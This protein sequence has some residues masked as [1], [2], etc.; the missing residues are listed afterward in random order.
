MKPIT[1]VFLIIGV[2]LLCFLVWT[3][4]FDNGGVLALAWN[5]IATEV[6]DMYA[7]INSLTHMK[8]N[9]SVTIELQNA[10]DRTVFDFV[11]QFDSIDKLYFMYYAKTGENT[12]N[13]PN[14]INSYIVNPN[15]VSDLFYPTGWSETIVD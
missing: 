14:L 11:Y 12:I 2:L 10:K 15:N 1:K 8:N 9:Y 3:L 7:D 5:A 4:V 13:N 6:N